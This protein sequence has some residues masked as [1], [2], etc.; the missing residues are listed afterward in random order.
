MIYR[1]CLKKYQKKILYEK[2]KPDLFEMF[3]NADCHFNH[4]SLKK[5]NIQ[6]DIQFRQLKKYLPN[7]RKHLQKINKN[8]VAIWN[9]FWKTQTNNNEQSQSKFVVTFCCII[10]YNK[11]SNILKKFLQTCLIE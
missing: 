7:H 1:S 10:N 9:G 8:D 11:L 3:R 6:N 2:G 5:R 4:Y